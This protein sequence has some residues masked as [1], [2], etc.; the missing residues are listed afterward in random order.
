MKW[1]SRDNAR[2]SRRHSAFVVSSHGKSA[3]Q[4][5]VAPAWRTV[6]VIVQTQNREWAP[7]EERVGC[8]ASGRRTGCTAQQWQAAVVVTGDGVGGGVSDTLLACNGCREE[9]G[10]A[11]WPL[12]VW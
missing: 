12:A 9:S 2:K 3:G 5:V 7:R 8:H 10:V 1:Q 11:R 4:I 6:P